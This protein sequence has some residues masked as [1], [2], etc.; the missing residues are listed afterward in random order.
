MPSREVS[1][2]WMG[3]H[4]SFLRS[5][6]STNPLLSWWPWQYLLVGNSGLLVHC[7]HTYTLQCTLYTCTQRRERVN[8][9]CLLVQGLV[10]ILK[11][12]P[13]KP[14]TNSKW[15]GIY[16]AQI[17]YLIL[18]YT[19]ATVRSSPPDQ[20]VRTFWSCVCDNPQSQ[21]CLHWETF[22]IFSRQSIVAI[23]RSRKKKSDLC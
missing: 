16:W 4:Q 6:L 11:L 19:I 20:K 2:N 14:G 23:E 15:Q 8:Q 22:L 9:D 21:T 7:S 13:K 10:P 12:P 5:C 17:K 1:R 18:R 3:R